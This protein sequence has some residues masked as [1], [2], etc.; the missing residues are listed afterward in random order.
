MKVWKRYVCQTAV[1]NGN[2]ICKTVGRITPAIYNQMSAAVNV[3]QGLYYYGPF[4]TQLADCTFVRETFTA[5]SKNNCPG[6]D[7]YSDWIYIGLEMVSAA[8]MLSLVFWLIYARERRHRTNN[9]QPLSQSGQ[10]YDA[11][12]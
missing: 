10:P 2:E 9:K 6:L 3:T 12:R 4:L 8:V 11:Y 7:L 1:V 5:L